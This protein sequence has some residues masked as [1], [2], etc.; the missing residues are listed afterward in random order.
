MYYAARCLPMSHGNV[1][2]HLHDIRI[3][4]ECEKNPCRYRD[5]SGQNRSPEGTNKKRKKISVK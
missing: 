2:F 3:H 5:R 4:A 1:Y